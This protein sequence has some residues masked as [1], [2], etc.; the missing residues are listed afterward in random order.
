MSDTDLEPGQMIIIKEIDNP[1]EY[2]VAV[3]KWSM[4]IGNKCRAGLMFIYLEAGNKI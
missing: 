4:K 3:V 2:K 1:H